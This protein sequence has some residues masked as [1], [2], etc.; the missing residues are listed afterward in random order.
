[1]MIIYFY[2]HLFEHNKNK[3]EKINKK[4]VGK[5]LFYF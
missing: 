3:K 4:G 1:M 5:P 2:T